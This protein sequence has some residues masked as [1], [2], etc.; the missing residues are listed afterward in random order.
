MIKTRL[1]SSCPRKL[2]VF[3]K[4]RLKHHYSFLPSHYVRTCLTRRRV[5]ISPKRPSTNMLTHGRKC[6]TIQLQKFWLTRFW[7][8]Q[9][10]ILLTIPVYINLKK[11]SLR[12]LQPRKYCHN[13]MAAVSLS[14]QI[15]N[16]RPEN[17]SSCR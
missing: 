3:P 1:K 4:H 17:C 8:S 11:T 5:I 10:S 2:L 7:V 12:I 6:F 9:S 16:L 15:T 14:P 13:T